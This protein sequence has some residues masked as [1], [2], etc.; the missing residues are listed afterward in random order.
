MFG[1]PANLEAEAARDAAFPNGWFAVA[2]A[3]DL[4]PLGVIPLRAFGRDLVLWRTEDGA[5]HVADA[6]CP[7]YGAHMGR[8]GKVTDDGLACPIHGL[9]FDRAGQCLPVRPGKT[10]PG[11]SIRTYPTRELAGAVHVW[12]DVEQ[13]SPTQAGPDASAEGF[14]PIARWRWR[15]GVSFEEVV[16]RISRLPSE[17]DVGDAS[18]QLRMY[19]TPEDLEVTQVF[20]VSSEQVK[21]GERI[22]ETALHRL[23]AVLGQPESDH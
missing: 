8:G 20:V 6:A 10:A 14:A 2:L 1:G 16:A 15:P 4:G 9:R 22:E 5:A 21:G 17:I 18:A 11:Y 12:R 13:Q 23:T 19:V 7:H 3:R